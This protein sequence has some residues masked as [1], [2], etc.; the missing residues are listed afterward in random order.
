MFYFFLVEN[1]LFDASQYAYF[2]QKAMDEVELGGL[3]DEEDGSPAVGYGDDEYHLF[4]KE[5]VRFVYYLNTI[6]K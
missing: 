2:G 1:A 5:E 4:D 3:E 6:V